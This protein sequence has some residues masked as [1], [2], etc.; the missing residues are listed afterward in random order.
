MF[1]GIVPDLRYEPLGASSEL[2]IH[3]VELRQILALIELEGV[4]CGSGM[5]CSV[6]EF[7]F[8]VAPSWKRYTQPFVHA[9]YQ[10]QQ[11]YRVG[12]ENGLS[13]P[14]ETVYRVIAGE[15]EDVAE[16]EAGQR[17]QS[18]FESIAIVILT[19][20]VD[21]DLG[22]A[23]QQFAAQRFGSDVRITAGVVGETD[24]VDSSAL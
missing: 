24:G 8:G 19:R 16:S 23:I 4:D 12:V 21:Y 13:L 7:S 20:E 10:L 17:P 3:L 11:T 1:S 14:R 15:T 5:E 9:T 18:S 6:S 2:E 22:I